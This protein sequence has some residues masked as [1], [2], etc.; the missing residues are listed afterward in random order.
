MTDQAKRISDRVD[1]LYEKF[2]YPKL[3]VTESRVSFC[4]NPNQM[5][6]E[7]FSLGKDQ[8]AFKVFPTLNSP[9]YL[10]YRDK[11]VTCGA[12][13]I[14][15]TAENDVQYI[16]DSVNSFFLKEDAKKLHLQEFTS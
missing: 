14:N 7:L 16:L 2:P 1:A 12:F 11:G 4:G 3:R 10:E 6:F 8:L 9:Y 5:E 13:E 15:D